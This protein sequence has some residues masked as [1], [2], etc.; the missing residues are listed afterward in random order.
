EA[1]PDPIVLLTHWRINLLL[2]S[3]AVAAMAAYGFGVLR[4]RRRGDS[5]P[6][7]R[8]IC[9]VT[10]WIITIVLMSSGLGKYYPADFGI[11]MIVHMT[12]NILLTSFLVSVS[13]IALM[14]QV[15]SL[16]G[17]LVLNTQQTGP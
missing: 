13:Q 4:L 10:G 17:H 14:H 6:V 12:L 15:S 9:W 2:T 1:A 5:W 8:T 3:V 16:Y 11:H 7:I